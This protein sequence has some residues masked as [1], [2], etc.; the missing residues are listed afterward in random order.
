MNINSSPDIILVDDDHICNM[1]NELLIKETLPNSDIT[2]FSD[3]I[4]AYESLLE[5]LDSPKSYTTIIFLDINMPK[6]SGWELLDA[7][8][9]H[10]SKVRQRYKIYMLSSSLDPRD[11]ENA[12][13]NPLVSGFFE[14]PLNR[15]DFLTTGDS[16]I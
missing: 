3:P 5:S 15:F 11:N 6:M 9:D 4:D 10:I 2:I 7:L 1:L 14:K 8:K 13:T 16:H 12:K